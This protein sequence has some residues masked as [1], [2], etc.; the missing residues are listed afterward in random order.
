[1]PLVV[2]HGVGAVVCFSNHNINVFSWILV[3][4]TYKCRQIYLYVMDELSLE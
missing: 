4:E 3:Y 2:Q 1:M